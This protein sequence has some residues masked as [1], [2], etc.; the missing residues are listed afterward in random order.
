ML[1][2]VHAYSRSRSFR[3]CPLSTG[4]FSR[5]P[6]E[7]IWV[8]L[9]NNL[10]TKNCRGDEGIVTPTATQL[11]AMTRMFS[12]GVFR[13][14]AKR[15]QSPLFTRLLGLA[16]VGLLCASNATVGDAF[17][18][19]FA[20]LKTTGLRDEYVYRAAL[21]HKVLMGTHSLKTACMLNEFR[22]GA[23]KADLA[24][25][26][27]TATVYEIKSERDSLARLANQVD[28][29][30]KVFGKV[31]VIAGETHIS[32]VVKTVPEDVG[33]MCLS[34]RYQIGTIREAI[35]RADRICT[36]TVF[37]SVRSAEAC[38]ILKDL[39]VAIPDVPNTLLHGKMRECFRRLKPED[40]HT[41][42]VKTLKRTRNLAPL[43]QLVEQ[44]P[45]SL[46]AAALSI[47]V[48]R[49]DHD[50]LIEAVKTPLDDAMAWV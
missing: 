42:M 10:A 2:A 4:K 8:T 25:L 20:M 33:V 5:F 7:A 35:D 30:K 38:A 23:C 14:M 47:Q 31:Y 15:G 21:T 39:G 22:V 28:N 24:I 40:V 19:A 1:R 29:Y 50:R 36:A 48:R 13:E 34:R 26:N 32:G 27:G 44:L 12:S 16:K 6:P 17:D 9:N 11:S 43:S 18:W 46:H 3:R 49:S 45:P 37:E 41:T